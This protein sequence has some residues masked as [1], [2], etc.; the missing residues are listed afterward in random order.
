MSDRVH[1]RRTVSPHERRSR[2]EWR[3]ENQ[4]AV[5]S[6]VNGCALIEGRM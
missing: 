4:R 3:R 2:K 1:L 6:P 5:L